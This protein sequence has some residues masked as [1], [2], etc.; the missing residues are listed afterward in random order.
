MNAPKPQAKKQKITAKSS[1]SS[2]P[3]AITP[4]VGG[5]GQTTEGAQERP[6]GKKKEKHMLH[7]CASM[8]AMEYF[9]AKKEEADA[10][11]ELKKEVQE[12]LRASGRKDR[13]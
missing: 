6:P 3:V 10:E 7:Q 4:I 12:G 1:S 9:V 2:A 8:E 13:N 11:K 5:D